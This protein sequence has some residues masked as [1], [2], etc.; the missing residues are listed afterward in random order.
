MKRAA[1]DVYRAMTEG[2]PTRIDASE[3]YRG[4]ETTCG[5]YRSAKL[6]KSLKRDELLSD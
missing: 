2:G 5:I 6:G 1:A 3:A 4:L